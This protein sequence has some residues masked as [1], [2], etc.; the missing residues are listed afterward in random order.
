MAEARAEFRCGDRRVDVGYWRESPLSCTEHD[1]AI[2][3][4][5]FPSQME[6][7]KTIT[8]FIHWNTH[9]S[10]SHTVSAVPIPRCV[11]HLQLRWAYFDLRSLL[12]FTSLHN[13]K[14][15][16]IGI[17][18]EPKDAQWDK[19]VRFE[20]LQYLC[21][22]I[23]YPKENQSTQFTSQSQWIDWFECPAL[24]DLSLL[25]SILEVTCDETYAQLEAWLLN[26]MS[27]QNLQVYM[28]V[29]V[30]QEVNPVRLQ[31]MQ[32]STFNGTL[33][34]VKLRFSPDLRKS[35]WRMALTER[36]FSVFTPYTHL[37]WPYGQFPSPAIFI[38]L[39]SMHIIH[40]VDGSSSAL[41]PLAMT[42]VEFPLLEELFLENGIIE[43]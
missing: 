3:T 20:L 32:H 21:L 2:G 31:N 4:I 12:P 7:P 6:I 34:L 10:S 43:L 13:L 5:V 9:T 24:V 15:L 39:K 36:F 35:E 37:V 26:F 42:E 8:P 28:D 14:S 38:H 17:N 23:S 18:H 30:G 29:C 1:K 22:S 40:M 27:L 19:K 33:E 11:C 16:S 25:C 41:V